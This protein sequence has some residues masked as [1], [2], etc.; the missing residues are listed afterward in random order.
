[1]ADSTRLIGINLPKLADSTRLMMDNLS[2]VVY[3]GLPTYPGGI[4]RATYPPWYIASLYTLG[5]LHPPGTHATV[6]VMYEAG[7]SAV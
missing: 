5:T 4:C 2:W 3:A 7:I 1:M 6:A